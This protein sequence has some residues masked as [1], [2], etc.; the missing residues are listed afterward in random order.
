M[1]SRAG[2]SRWFVGSSRSSRFEGWMP[3][4]ASSSRERSPPDSARTSLSTSSPRNRKRARYERAS[5]SVT[6]MTAVSASSTVV[7]G[8]AAPRSWAR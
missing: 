1:A 6:G 8:R 2:M 7:P 5:P 4:M 3:R